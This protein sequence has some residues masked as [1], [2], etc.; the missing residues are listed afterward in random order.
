MGRYKHGHCKEH[1][2]PAPCRYCETLAAYNKGAVVTLLI[3]LVVAF[4]WGMGR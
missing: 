4:A 2:A 3:A 1:G